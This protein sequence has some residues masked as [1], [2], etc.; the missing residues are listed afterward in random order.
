MDNF[1][2]RKFLAENRTAVSGSSVETVNEQEYRFRDANDERVKLLR[3]LL[4][5]VAEQSANAIMKIAESGKFK[6]INDQEGSI[7]NADLS[8]AL[9]VEVLAALQEKI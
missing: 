6:K 2:L 5:S 9:G 8:L 4:K 3:P 1:D 7:G